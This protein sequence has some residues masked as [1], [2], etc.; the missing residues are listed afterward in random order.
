MFGFLKKLVATPKAVD[1]A[2]D[3]VKSGIDGIGKCFFTEQEKAEF[4]LKAGEM[5]IRVQES[6]AQESGIRSMTRRI[7]AIMGMGTFM[8]FLI[9]AALAWP[10]LPEYSAFL[11][12]LAKELGGLTFAI[13]SFYFGIHLLRSL[14]K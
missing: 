2:L 6:L 11:L 3:G 13:T 1:V 14:K 4:T 12:S 5:W 10:F 9:G 8:F 7:L